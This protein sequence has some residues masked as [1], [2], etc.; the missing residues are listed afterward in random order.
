[1]SLTIENHC[2][3]RICEFNANF[4]MHFRRPDLTMPDKIKN[5]VA[6]RYFFGSFCVL[7]IA[8]LP[9][10]KELSGLECY[11][12]ILI[13]CSLSLGMALITDRRFKQTIADKIAVRMGYKNQS[14]I[15]N[16]FDRNLLYSF[17]KQ[18]HLNLEPIDSYRIKFVNMY[19]V[20]SKNL[21]SFNQVM[22]SLK[23]V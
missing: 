7:L 10:L 16:D 20:S 14:S 21:I 8:T 6:S 17:L 13:M 18:N 2:Y 3:S 19:E 15:L 12:C 5:I 22:P 23:A 1:M 11:L 9:I 4:A